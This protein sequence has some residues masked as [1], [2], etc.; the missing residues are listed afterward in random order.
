MITLTFKKGNDGLIR[1]FIKYP[2]YAGG[3]VYAKDFQNKSK[4]KESNAQE[5]IDNCEYGN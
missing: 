4:L 2:N 5:L 3:L 1:F